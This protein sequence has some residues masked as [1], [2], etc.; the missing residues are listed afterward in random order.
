[1]LVPERR[2]GRGPGVWF[3]PMAIDISPVAISYT[4]ANADWNGLPWPALVRGDLLSAVRVAPSQPPVAAI[5]CNPPYVTT[6]EMG[7]L[8]PEI[9][10]HEPP[11]ALHGGPDG[12]DVIRR[13]LDQALPFVRWGSLLAFEI[14]AD[15]E[16][17]VRDE[18]ARRGI[19][20]LATVHTDLAL[21]PRVVLVEPV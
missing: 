12:L 2:G 6:G 15:Q 19:A 4:A 5:L 11:V 14:G 20:G 17:G 10:D 1:M 16:A 21:R 13:L 18:L 7:E 3:R 8:P 9:R